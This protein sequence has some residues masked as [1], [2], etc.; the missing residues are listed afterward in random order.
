[1]D[2]EDEKAP[3]VGPAFQVPDDWLT[4]LGHGEGQFR[5]A[6]VLLHKANGHSHVS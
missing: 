2:D 6:E 4:A 5:E 1:V 3:R